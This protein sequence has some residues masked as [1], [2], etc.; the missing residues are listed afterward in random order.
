MSFPARKVRPLPAMIA[1][2]TVGLL[3]ACGN[4]PPPAAATPALETTAA[5]S[6]SQA[7]QH[8]LELEVTGTASPSL[9]FVLDGK[10]TEETATTLPWRKTIE[11][12]YG[13]GDH[14]WTLTLRHDGGKLSA[15][16][17]TDG[18][19]VT[20]TAGSGSPGSNN[21]ATLKGSFTD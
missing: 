1:L 11:V 12:P 4:P 9:T 20:R 21:T 2:V 3:G 10:T 15:T 7:Q 13:T 8:K 14:E 5:T 16:A 19:L 17:T 6:P 18:T